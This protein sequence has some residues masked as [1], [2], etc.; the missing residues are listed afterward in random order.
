M[1]WG[2]GVALGSQAPGAQVNTAQTPGWFSSSRRVRPRVLPQRLVLP[3]QSCWDGQKR[4]PRGSQ[5]PP[6]HPQR[7][8]A[9][10]K[11]DCTRQL[12]P[13]ATLGNSK[14]LFPLRLGNHGP[15]PSFRER[16]LLNLGRGPAACQG[17][18][19]HPVGLPPSAGPL[20]PGREGNS[21][22]YTHLT[23]THS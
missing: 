4:E 23:G 12:L 7:K 6:E 17:R 21:S 5:H 15:G 20:Q 1:D 22:D 14:L 9:G 2:R 3:P 11:P 13:L 18:S 19:Y 10:C 16:P 8:R